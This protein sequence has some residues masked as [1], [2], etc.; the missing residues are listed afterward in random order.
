MNERARKLIW[1]AV[2]LG[3]GAALLAWAFVTL[4]PQGALSPS[5]TASLGDT[6]PGL[7]LIGKLIP[8]SQ[9]KDHQALAGYKD[10]HKGACGTSTGCGGEV[11]L[12]P[13]TIFCAEIQGRATRADCDDYAAQAKSA[14][15]GLGAFNTPNPMTRGQTTTLQ[16]AVS[17]KP[18]Q[19]PADG[20]KPAT[21]IS[22]LDGKPVAFEPSVGRHM[23]AELDGEGF[24]IT[25]QGPQHRELVAGSITSWEWVIR[26]DRKGDH[27]LVLKTTVEAAK[28]D[29][30]WTPLASTTK[31]QTIHVLVGKTDAVRDALDVIPGWVRSVTTIV[32]AVSAL[33]GA[34]VALIHRFRKRKGR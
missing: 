13:A 22:G 34:V 19:V 4:K 10:V 12:P 9:P 11:A 17:F 27:V 2:T 1:R 32:V 23:A 20:E 33:V 14:K 31:D 15:A 8:K 3:L 26:A 24:T 5:L 7:D 30:G 29:G 21:V 28:A 18:P 25:P 16:L 6:L